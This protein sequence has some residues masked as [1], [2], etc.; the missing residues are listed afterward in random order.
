MDVSRHSHLAE[1]RNELDQFNTSHK[2]IEKQ[3][4][5]VHSNCSAANTLQMQSKKELLDEVPTC[6][7]CFC[8]CY[9]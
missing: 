5:R 2:Q 3:V 6:Y 4:Y 9:D 1:L 7:F 8:C